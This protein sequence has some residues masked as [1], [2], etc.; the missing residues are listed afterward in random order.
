MLRQRHLYLGLRSGRDQESKR[1]GHSLA[2]LDVACIYFPRSAHAPELYISA[3]LAKGDS[4]VE[5]TMGPRDPPPEGTTYVGE[6][7]LQPIRETATSCDLPVSCGNG[8]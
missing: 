5:L 3:R 7:R 8:L 2:C 4:E 6:C 1:S